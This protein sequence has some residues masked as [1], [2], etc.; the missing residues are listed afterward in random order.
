MVGGDAGIRV[1]VTWSL[2]ELY[3][4]Q[5]RTAEIRELKREVQ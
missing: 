4:M 2:R 1:A 3:T 5:D